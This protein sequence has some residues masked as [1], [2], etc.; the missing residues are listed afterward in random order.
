[1]GGV[2]VQGEGQKGAGGVMS[3]NYD[4]WRSSFWDW[5]GWPELFGIYGTLAGASA[6]VFSGQMS[7]WSQT[8]I[9]ITSVIAAI[10]AFVGVCVSV[11][12]HR[13]DRR[14]REV[15]SAVDAERRRIENQQ[16]DFM[17][18]HD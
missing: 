16:S 13:K 11:A 7:V 15:R 12:H 5:L 18:M 6:L 17:N 10:V 9:A 14:D 1:V 3:E 4:D 8:V 2:S